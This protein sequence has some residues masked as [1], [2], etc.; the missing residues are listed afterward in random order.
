MI[1]FAGLA[2]FALSAA[3]APDTPPA[4]A[5]TAAPR[6]TEAD[7][8]PPSSRHD[9]AKVRADSARDKPANA[10]ARWIVHV[11]A[12]EDGTP[13]NG[14]QIDVSGEPDWP[15][16]TAIDANGDVRVDASMPE[17]VPAM[18][19]LR[20]RVAAP[21]RVHEV[22]QAEVASGTEQQT[23]V[24]LHRAFGVDG[25]V[26]DARGRPIGG[27]RVSARNRAEADVAKD[28]EAPVR[29][30]LTSAV[31]SGDGRFRIEGLPTRSA[32]DYDVAAQRHVTK[33][34]SRRAHDAHPLDVQLDAA[35]LLRGVV[36][37][38]DGAPV[39]GALVTARP[40]ATDDDLPHGG[41]SGTPTGRD[42]RFEI[43]ALPLGGEFTLSAGHDD[44]M[45][46]ADSLPIRLTAEC[47]EASCD[48]ALRPAGRLEV[49]LAFAH[50]HDPC[51]VRLEWDD[52]EETT[53]C[54][55]PGRTTRVVRDPETLA[56]D[57]RAEGLRSV[58]AETEVGPGETQKLKI[59][60]DEGESMSG[61]VV[62]D[63][64]TPV[65]GA[66]VKVDPGTPSEQHAT[67]AADGTFTVKGLASEIHEV[68]TTAADH[69]ASDR[70][71]MAASVTWM[72]I[73][74]HRN[75]EA[76][77]RLRVPDGAAR[78]PKRK[79]V[80]LGPS[81]GD[82]D[83]AGWSDG[84]VSRS[85]PPGYWNVEVEVSGYAKWKSTNPFFIVAGRRTDLGEV[86]LDPGLPL[87]GRVVDDAGQS[88]P[89]IDV[90]I[91]SDLVET[92][93]T[94]QFKAAHAAAGDHRVVAP[95]SP[96]CLGTV[97]RYRLDADSQ[98]LVLT[99]HRGAVLRVTLRGAV[100]A[101]MRKGMRVEAVP[102]DLPAD[103][104]TLFEEA[105]DRYSARLPAVA[106]RIIVHCDNRILAT[107][108]VV[109]RDGEDVSVEIALDK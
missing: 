25:L 3:L 67:S 55:V 77:L 109:L 71:D 68:R 92:D 97:L 13:V 11:V 105:P 95:V 63:E 32:V 28:E 73:E 99:V 86:V 93:A 52:G 84:V 58:S 50:E 5:T 74:V 40:A 2:W 66:L 83:V 39:S 54:S 106:R 72:R 1:A 64:G 42:G 89:D 75:G 81:P 9:V 57:V 8:L 78:P 41:G 69:A 62:D 29:P 12:A 104:A 91:D 21:G 31:S 43:D 17:L 53:T 101:M 103:A 88:V 108:D 47:G 24:K 15:R 46:S 20:L 45:E 85:L 80:W 23:T 14:A 107:K 65:A 60:L 96:D 10:P 70:K 35:G 19:K 18:V 38:P 7:Q 82:E 4:V 79:I 44:F 36:R 22:A 61:T 94:G 87:A 76:A 37:S 59:E 6:S 48:L 16:K 30:E 102:I 100:T 26:H 27:A 56:F 98:P 51:V 49:E 90:F 33:R 34:I